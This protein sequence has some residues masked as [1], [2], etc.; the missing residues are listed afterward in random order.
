MIPDRDEC[1]RLMGR[2]GMLEHIVAHSLEVTRVA[3][4]L[5]TELNKNGQRLDLRLVEAGS[6][7][8]DIAKT[9][10]LQTKEDHTREG[11]RLLTQMGYE[12][13]GEIV[14]QHVWL[15]GEGDASAVSEEEVVNYADKRVRHDQIVSLG[16]RFLD[17][18]NRYGRDQRSTDYLE[19]LEKL[20]LG[21]EN[22]IFLILKI[23]PDDVGK[24][25]SHFHG[26]C[27]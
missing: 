10:C 5:C 16:E 14:A 26:P 11:C 19:R 20:I 22:K 12:K 15:T 13:V 9:R 18:K 6:L 23:D 21:I 17:L 7:L 8:H 4:F 1:L 24:R 3:L 25:V 27:I 2:H